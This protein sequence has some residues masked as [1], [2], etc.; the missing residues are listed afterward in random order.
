MMEF[1][2]NAGVYKK[3]N[4]IHSKEYWSYVEFNGKKIGVHKILR[5]LMLKFMKTD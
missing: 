1:M 5:E 2:K 4:S 3:N